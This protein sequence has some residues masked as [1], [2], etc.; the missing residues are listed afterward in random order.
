MV[1]ARLALLECRIHSCGSAVDVDILVSFIGGFM[2][3]MNQKKALGISLKAFA[4]LMIAVC[5]IYEMVTPSVKF[6]SLWFSYIVGAVLYA[7]GLLMTS[8]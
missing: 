1:A 5:F 2:E 6:L 3:G 7:I 8:V 4:V